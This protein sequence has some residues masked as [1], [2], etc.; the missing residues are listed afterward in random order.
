MRCNSF[1]IV[2][3]WWFTF[4]RVIW[5]NCSVFYNVLQTELA[6]QSAR[7]EGSARL[8]L[9]FSFVTNLFP[10]LLLDINKLLQIFEDQSYFLIL[11]ENPVFQTYCP[12]IRIILFMIISSGIII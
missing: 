9:V 2:K 5:L 8:L 3:E 7:R 6:R 1:G 4:N 10:G 11:T 12:L